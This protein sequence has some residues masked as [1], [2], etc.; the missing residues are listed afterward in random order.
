MEGIAQGI[1]DARQKVVD[2]FDTLK[3]L[4]KHPLGTLQEQARLAGE[5]TGKMLA[6]GLH[7]NDEGIRDFSR[8]A[9]QYALDQLTDLAAKSGHIS[10]KASAAIE[11]GLKS[12]NATIRKNSADAKLAYLNGLEQY[13]ERGGKLSKDAAA[14]VERGIKSKNSQIHKAA[15]HIKELA[16]KPLEAAKNGAYATARTSAKTFASGPHRPG[17]MA[18]IRDNAAPRRRRS[19]LPARQVA[20]AQGPA[21]HDRRGRRER[22]EGVG[23]GPRQRA[24]RRVRRLAGGRPAV[25]PGRAPRGRRGLPA[26]RRSARLQRGGA[27]VSRPTLGD[28][29]LMELSYVGF[30]HPQ[31]ATVTSRCSPPTRR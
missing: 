19:R 1:F 11:N 22:H 16:T 24:R 25:R 31:R 14:A 18:R 2:A 10:A 21:A 3:E 12:K 15:L 26:G 4:L 29:E 17:A 23:E 6:K 20:A 7:S 28:L 9:K 27:T 13:V 8:S 5:L 30:D